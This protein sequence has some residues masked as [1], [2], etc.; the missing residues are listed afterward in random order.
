MAASR[1]W[2]RCSKLTLPV[3]VHA[4]LQGILIRFAT[5][6]DAAAVAD[7]ARYHLQ[8]WNYVRS[9]AY[10]S[11]H[12]KL[13]GT[14]GQETLPLR[15]HLS[16][17][18]HTVLVVV[19]EMKPVMQMQLDYD[20]RS[21]QGASLRDTLYLTVHAIDALD[22]VRAGFGSL[23]WRASMRRATTKP[24]VVAT[25]VSAALGATLYQQ[26]G[27]VGCHSIDG[28][29]AGKT[30]PTFKGLYGSDVKLS[31]GV[32]RRA[33]DDYLR[34]A[35]LDPAREIVQGF[36]PGMPSY[37]GVLSDAEVASLIR[38]LRSLGGRAGR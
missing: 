10:G 33:N 8:R 15:A 31:T 30:G 34:R 12:F 18:G 26:K 22:L 21:R 19:P 27:C 16:Q 25:A 9:S 6:L 3:A 11:G 5:P 17:D 20:L 36:E 35:I 37:R 1:S 4:G 29:H 32:T 23:D 7:P 24:S 2:T 28:T 14:P 38:Y 13:D